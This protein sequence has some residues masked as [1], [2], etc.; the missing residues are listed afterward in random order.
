MVADE[1]LVAFLVEDD[2][3]EAVD[4]ANSAG[5]ELVQ[6]IEPDDDRFQEMIWRVDQTLVRL[7]YDHFVDVGYVAT[8][9]PEHRALAEQFRTALNGQTLDD[10]IALAKSPHAGH[11]NVGLPIVGALAPKAYDSAVFETLSA[12]ASD[13]EE[14]IRLN[15]LTVISRVA[16]PEFIPVVD[17]LTHDQDPQIAEGAARLV[18]LLRA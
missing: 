14:D 1:T 7:I 15:L 13:P 8:Q 10:A 9:G 16:W 5:W 2:L 12:M 3:G 6:E 17:G 4:L 11:R 18:Q